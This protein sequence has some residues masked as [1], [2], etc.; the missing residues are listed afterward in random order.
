MLWECTQLLLLPY[1]YLH[2]QAD[3]IMAELDERWKQVRVD[4]D[5]DMECVDAVVS[6]H[7]LY[8]DPHP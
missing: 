5:G 8:Q 1:S 4:L 3:Q 6:P 2:S 7:E